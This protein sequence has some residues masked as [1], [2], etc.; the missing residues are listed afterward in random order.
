MEKNLEKRENY[1]LTNG[2]FPE[3]LKPFEQGV[4]PAVAVGKAAGNLV[5]DLIDGIVD[6]FCD[7]DKDK[8]TNN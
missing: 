8:K 1:D 5:S 2:K 3:E 4:G 6:L 7:D